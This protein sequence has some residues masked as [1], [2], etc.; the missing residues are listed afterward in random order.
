MSHPSL[1][2]KD[3]DPPGA[4]PRPHSGAKHPAWRSAVADLPRR[5]RALWGTP[6]GKILA[7][8]L[9]LRLVSLFWGL[10]NADGWDDDGVA[11]RDFLPGVLQTY[12]PG[13]HY[14]YPPLQLILL[15]FVSAPVWIAT[16][17]HAPSLS[18]AAVVTTFINVPTMTALAVIGRLVSACLSLGLLWNVAKIGEDLRGSA[19]A[20][21]WVAAAC[22]LNATYTYYSQTTNLDGPYLFWGVWSLRW[23][24]HAIVHR[25]PSAL[26][27]SLILAALSV[28]T[29]DQAYA[30]FVLAVP[31]TLVAWLALDPGARALW[32]SI[33]K[34]VA[35]G[36]ALALALLLLIDGAVFN[37]AGFHDRLRFLLGTG[38]Q[39][40]AYYAKTWDG[41][42]HLLRDLARHFDQFY[43]VVFAPFA[44]M[45]LVVATRT[46]DRGR[47]AAG[48]VPLFAALSFTIAFDM[49]AR[50]TEVR[51][52]L[53]QSIMVGVYIGLAFDALQT[54]VASRTG[55][56]PSTWWSAVAA[57]PLVVMA[58]FGCL[59][60][61]AAMLLDPRYDAEEWLVAHLKPGDHVEVYDNNVHLPRF[62]ADALVERVDTTPI[63]SRNPL[64]DVQEVSDRF[65]NVEARRPGFIVVSDFWASKYL[66]DPEY[67]KSIGLVPSPTQVTLAKDTDSRTYFRALLG[68]DLN[69]RRAHL[70]G[71]TSTFWPRV[72]IHASLTREVWIFERKP[73]T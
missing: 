66:V 9:L 37:P 18:P 1:E 35:I 69:Y 29:K 17:I 55:S 25:K 67:L 4:T 41:R 73:G 70:S 6:L 50:R 57:A 11:P 45:G 3:L 20:G 5:A 7:L 26:R 40:H 19:R 23:L 60:V 64:L 14:T 8:A 47:R 43:P 71:W 54:W 33:S 53:P 34:E 28:A 61:D 56:R 10:P 46:P 52:V 59:A 51:F 48:L 72:D 30:L 39:D 58:L 12:S 38:S 24:V 36:A 63:T 31:V 15:A 2:R 22:A 21:T 62:P 65:S 44:A 49:V 32:R 13:Q 42:V 16:L 68:G 27:R